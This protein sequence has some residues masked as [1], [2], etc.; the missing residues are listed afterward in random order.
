MRRLFT[1][2][3]LFLAILGADS[4]TAQC[5]KPQ[6][7][8]S[9]PPKFSLLQYKVAELEPAV[10]ETS[11]LAMLHGQLVTFNDSGNDPSL[12]FLDPTS[13]K[14][15][16]SVKIAATNRDWEALAIDTAADGDQYYLGDIGNNGGDRRD[17]HVY[18]FSLNDQKTE[19]DSADIT[20]IHLSYKN[21]STFER[22]RLQTD[23]DA[24]AMIFH[25]GLLHIFSKEWDSYRTRHYT[26]Q[27]GLTT[28]SLEETECLDT[29]Y[30]VTDAAI[31]QETLYLIGYTKKM[32]V[33]LSVLPLKTDNPYFAK[34]RG[35]KYYLGSSLSLGQVEGITV[36]PDGMYI[37]S[38]EFRHPLG[39][40]PPR[41]Y[42]IPLKNMPQK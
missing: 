32:E 2:A 42:H 28:V 4:L 6:N 30:L 41:L 35:K 19:V 11:G 3:S 31:Y 40:V 33:F 27:P 39:T 22:T 5:I 7:F 34:D 15:V 14:V 9:P 13:G 1:I 38:E 10:R 24:E 17:L 8:N 16:R 18:R 23:Y 26:V 25:Q 36:G 20:S 12:F 37:S 21:Q 29:N